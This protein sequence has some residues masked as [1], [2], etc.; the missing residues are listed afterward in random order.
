MRHGLWLTGVLMLATPPLVYGQAQDEITIPEAMRTAEPG[1]HHEL[2]KRLSG[3][4][5]QHFTLAAPPEG[6]TGEGE[7]K[8]ENKLILDGRFLQMSFRGL[9]LGG[10]DESLH[11]LGWDEGRQM[12]FTYDMNEDGE[13]VV[14]AEGAWNDSTS[15]LT[16]DGSVAGPEG[17]AREY[18]IRIT[19]ADPDRYTQEILFILPD[20]E[21]KLVATVRSARE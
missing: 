15:T 2:L 1:P 12:Y 11:F 3:K 19:F 7:G 8:A 10:P 18:R 16:M 6:I 13:F 14:G 17:E 4:W 21:E 20:G 9:D 5:V